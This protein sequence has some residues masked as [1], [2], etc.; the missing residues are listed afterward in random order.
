MEMEIKSLIKEIEKL[1]KQTSENLEL[2]D[3]HIENIGKQN[4]N[5]SSIISETKDKDIEKNN[6]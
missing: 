2:A 6:E 4:P 3:K 1:F 5:N